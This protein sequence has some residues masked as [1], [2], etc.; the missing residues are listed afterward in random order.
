MAFARV[1]VCRRGY[2][3]RLKA[4]TKSVFHVAALRLKKGNLKFQYYTG[5]ST[6]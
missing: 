5:E 3:Q 2:P 4:L 6:I 1:V